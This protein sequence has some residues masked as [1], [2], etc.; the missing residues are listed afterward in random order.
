MYFPIV[1][2]GSI[3]SATNLAATAGDSPATKRSISTSEE[4]DGING[5]SGEPPVKR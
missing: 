2:V 5:E 1:I 4:T 3:R